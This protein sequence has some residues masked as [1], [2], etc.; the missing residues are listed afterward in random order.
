M[1][2]LFFDLNVIL[3][4][5][6][7]ACMSMFA[8]TLDRLPKATSKKKMFLKLGKNYEKEMSEKLFILKSLTQEITK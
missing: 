4:I 3:L 6:E 2:L 5:M 1:I 8:V 7:N